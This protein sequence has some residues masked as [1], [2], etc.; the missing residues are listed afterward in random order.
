MDLIQTTVALSILLCSLTAG[1]VLA[2][3][4]V[5][6]PGIRNLNDGSFLR[7]FKVIDR[8]IQNNQPVFMLVWVGSVVALVVSAVIGMLRL[9]G[10]D[11]LL[12]ILA[13][14]IYLL[15]VQL[16]TATINIPL[17]NWLQKQ[18]LDAL[19]G[20][21]LRDARANFESRWNRWNAVRTFFA[22]VACA[23]LIVLAL[24]L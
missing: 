19:T 14:A 15:G 5:V 18:D 21:E 7:S 22:T 12:V 16:P 9:D 8:V 10:V 23:L 17:N 24:R 2:F 3:A 11:L 6:M 13:T 4:S 1:I 20:P